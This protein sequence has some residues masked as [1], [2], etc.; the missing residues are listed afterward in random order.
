M[1]PDKKNSYPFFNTQ[2]KIS[3]K[4]GLVWTSVHLKLFDPIK[5]FSFQE[6]EGVC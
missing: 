3:A 5:L 1:L 6:K 2:F 4:I